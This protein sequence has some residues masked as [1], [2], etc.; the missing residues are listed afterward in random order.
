MKLLSLILC[1]LILLSSSSVHA[2]P[3]DK[4]N[5]PKYKKFKRGAM[6]IV[7]TVDWEGR[8]LTTSNL[9]AMKR[10]RKKYPGV[11]MLHFLNAAY[12]TK[13]N[14]NPKIITQKIKSVLRP[15]DEHGL[16]I[17]A[18]KTLVESSGVKFRKHPNL[19]DRRLSN[20][21]VDCG[22][23]VSIEAYQAEEMQKIIKN[24]VKILTQN[25]FERP[26]SFRAG[27]WQTG[28]NVAK[29]LLKEG[30]H[31]DSSGT[32][33]KFIDR[34]WGNYSM[35]HNSIK[36][37]WPKMTIDKQPYVLLREGNKKLWEVPNN[38]SLADYTD[39]ND[40]LSIL[41]ENVDS[42]L[43]KPKLRHFVNIGFHQETAAS[44]LPRIDKAI[45]QIIIYSK[46]KGVPIQFSH[47]PL[48]FK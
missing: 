23:V 19:A 25:G 33:T 40:V 12:Y 34:S 11:P 7:M 30:F 9:S 2:W 45:Q 20:C 29:A 18:W 4:K 1:S 8:D 22:H 24:S 39:E 26:R 16:H 42:F 15:H 35:L 21:N 44:Y 47:L 14:A 28:P 17:H 31:M 13:I 41:K 36:K 48:R 43:K 38:G 6:V 10:F 27:A 37:L 46:K 3:W 5:D 32:V